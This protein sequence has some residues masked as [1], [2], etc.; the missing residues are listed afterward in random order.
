MILI[1]DGCK[2]A[3]RRKRVGRKQ[4]GRKQV[5]RHSRREAR[6]AETVMAIWTKTG[7]TR[8]WDAHLTINS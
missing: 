7:K 5:G 1:A 8:C 6:G 2:E 4:V 3:V